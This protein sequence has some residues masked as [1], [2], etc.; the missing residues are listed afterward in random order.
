MIYKSYGKGEI[1]IE[2]KDIFRYAFQ[3]KVPE[4]GAYGDLP[5]RA[6]AEILSAAESRAVY[7]ILPVNID[8]CIDFGVFKTDSKSLLKNMAGCSEAVISRLEKKIVSRLKKEFAKQKKF[9][10]P[11]FSPGYGDFSLEHQKDIFRILNLE[12]NLGITLTENLFMVPTKSVTAICA[13]S[14]INDN[15]ETE[16]CE[17]CDKR[18]TCPF[19]RA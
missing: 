15:C 8:K 4:D 10:R 19:C 12:K 1:P 11:R 5:E 7:E 9:L 17:I 2:K 6:A 14:E 3:K 18:S 13:I 16:G